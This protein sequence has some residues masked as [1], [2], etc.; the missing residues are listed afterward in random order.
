VYLTIVTALRMLIVNRHCFKLLR[1]TL[2]ASCKLSDSYDF[3]CY[4]A[5]N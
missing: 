1:M 2:S 4:I 5:V 3:Y